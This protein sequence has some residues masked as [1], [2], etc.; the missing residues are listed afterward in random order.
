[1]TPT[2]SVPL[3][4]H[5]SRVAGETACSLRLRITG[6]IRGLGLP[7]S[8]FSTL[9]PGLFSQG[10]SGFRR[11]HLSRSRGSGLKTRAGT[12]AAYSS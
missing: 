8:P 11:G 4:T 7:C 2:P 10:V 3:W 12:S 1:M 5:S 9:D 6:V